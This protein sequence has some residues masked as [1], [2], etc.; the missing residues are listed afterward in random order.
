MSLQR[1]KTWLQLESRAIAFNHAKNLLR[2]L[3]GRAKRYIKSQIDDPKKVAALTPDYRMGCKRI[4]ISNDYYAALNRDHVSIETTGIEKI[5]ENGIID[6][7]GTL[8]EVDV[9]IL[10]TGFQTLDAVK[11]LNINNGQDLTLEQA[12]KNGAQCHLG[13][14]VSGFPNFF[15]LLGPNTGLGHSSQVL[16]IESQ[17]AYVS[18]ALKKMKHQGIASV[19]V[20]PAVQDAFV[21]KIQSRLKQTIWATGCESWYLDNS[22]EN[23]TTWPG[24]TFAFRWMTRK[25]EINQ[26]VCEPV[27]LSDNK[28]N[29]TETPTAKTEEATVLNAMPAV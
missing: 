25:F 8:H 29:T 15:L 12:W 20:R 28:D 6:A 9:I 19:D 13:T 4:L 21:Q 14:M 17:I 22:G 2:L 10:G 3:E 7:S 5:T 1:G 18:D 11:G 27:A 26:H 23:W 16:M 24:F